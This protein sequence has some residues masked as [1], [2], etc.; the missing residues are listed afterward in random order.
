MLSGD[1][2]KQI[3]NYQFLMKN[4]LKYFI[5]LLAIML[6]IFFV[7]FVAKS[8]KSGIENND[9]NIAETEDI[10]NYSRVSLFASS[11]ER[12]SLAIPE[13]WEG[14]YR[15]KESGNKAVFL[16]IE[17]PEDIKEIFYI[18]KYKDEE[19][20]EAQN[21]ISEQEFYRED[22]YIYVYSLSTGESE[23]DIQKN[24]FLKMRKEI[25]KVIHSIKVFSK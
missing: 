24:N 20:S 11:N 8:K 16:Y 7:W 14:N 25:D 10:K 12:I 4:G 9:N 22:T 5:I 13:N 15:I 3:Y 17:K 2:E 6:I 1:K 23:S 19:W 18:K 21:N